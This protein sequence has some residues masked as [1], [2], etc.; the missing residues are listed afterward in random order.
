[1]GVTILEAHGK[2]AFAVV[3]YDEYKALLEVAEDADDVAALARC[4]FGASI[5]A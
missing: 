2:P 4:G 3:P 5:A 1:M